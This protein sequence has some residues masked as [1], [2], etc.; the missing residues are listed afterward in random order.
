MI[1]RAEARSQG[2]KRYFTGKPCYRYHV[3]ER[4]V[5]TGDCIG[6]RAEKAAPKREK[7]VRE[8]YLMS[9]EEAGARGLKRYSTGKPCRYGH[10]CERYTAQGSCVECVAARDVA[11]L[12]RGTK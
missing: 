9:R 3:A 4:Y 5:S 10:T 1:T 12:K 7:V 11:K 6:C 8:K 2:L